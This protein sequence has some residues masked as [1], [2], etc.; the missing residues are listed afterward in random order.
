MYSGGILHAIE[1]VGPVGAHR[2]NKFIEL[3]SVTDW[4]F[5]L[6]IKLDAF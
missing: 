5:A 2:S 4:V 3:S 1:K 6:R